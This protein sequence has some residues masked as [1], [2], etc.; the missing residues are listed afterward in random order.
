MTPAAQTPAAADTSS[1]DTSKIAPLPPPP[2]PPTHMQPLPQLSVCGTV[3]ESTHRGRP[4]LTSNGHA[5]TPVAATSASRAQARRDMGGWRG[6]EGWRTLGKGA[7]TQKKEKSD[8]F[9]GGQAAKKHPPPSHTRFC[10][11][12]VGLFGV[13]VRTM[14]KM[15]W[16]E[17]AR[18]RGRG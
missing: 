18:Q 1:T 12:R 17:I 11:V 5:A 13:H 3:D 14:K 10:V 7:N 2:S 16:F 8:D 9:A 15:D 6:W 4:V